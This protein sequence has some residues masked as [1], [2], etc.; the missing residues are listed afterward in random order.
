MTRFLLSSVA[1]VLLL[2]PVAAGAATKATVHHV[3]THTTK[4]TAHTTGRL[5]AHPS[6]G[7]TQAGDQAVDRL[8]QQSLDR[9]RAGTDSAPS[10]PAQ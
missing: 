4:H 10:A 9:A 5:G 8:N 6:G 1:A 7:R 3:A 2:A